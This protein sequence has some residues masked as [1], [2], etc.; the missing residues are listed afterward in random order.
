MPTAASSSTSHMELDSIR[1]SIETPQEPQFLWKNC[2]NKSRRDRIDI[3]QQAVLDGV[4][5]GETITSILRRRYN[6]GEDR[7]EAVEL[8]DW[9]KKFGEFLE[10]LGSLTTTNSVPD[11]VKDSYESFHFCVGLLGVLGGGKTSLINA[12]LDERELL[13]SSSDKAAT[14]VLCEVVYNHRSAGYLAEIVF[15]TRQSLADELNELFLKIKLKGDLTKQYEDVKGNFDPKNSGTDEDIE[16]ELADIDASIASTLETVEA[17]WG[18]DEEELK[19]MSTETLLKSHSL[20]SEIL[21]TMRRISDTNS[22]IFA[23]KIKPFLDSTQE[24]EGGTTGLTL[25]PLIEK[26]TIYTRSDILKYGLRLRDLPG[27][28]D[29]VERRSNV[30]EE[31]S[32]DLDIT[33][34]VAPAIRATEERTAVGLV[35]GYQAV[36]MQMDGKFNRSSF[37]VVLSKTDDIDSEVYLRRTKAAKN[38][39]EIQKQLARVK[40]LDKDFNNA[41]AGHRNQ[42]KQN[43]EYTANG[44]SYNMG[45]EGNRREASALKECLEQTAVSMRNRDIADRIQKSFLKRQQDARLLER[46]E[47]HDG[48]VEVF[49]TS[50]RAYWKS[51][52]PDGEKARGFPDEIHS[53]IPRLKQWLFES[54]FSQ[55]ERQLDTTLNGLL[56]LFVRIQDRISPGCAGFHGAK[57]MEENKLGLIHQRHLWV[58]EWDFHLVTRWIP[59]NHWDRNSPKP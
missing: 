6:G 22:E 29:A 53:G 3:K 34:I 40:E 43:R 1:D 45:I 10:F 57:R 41:G 28:G 58:S 48:A 59:A 16:D 7:T 52:H 54:M 4:R 14:A 56:T 47:L 37:C 42:E 17:V 35:K 31:N 18:F 55:R 5:L 32:T 49:G 2:A 51:K 39:V 15:R 26:V 19:D 8:S 36:R 12:L 20:D 50:A 38:D 46:D 33:A 13:P 30:A 44:S 11:A 21:G 27:L 25:W 9:D 23:Q 24:I